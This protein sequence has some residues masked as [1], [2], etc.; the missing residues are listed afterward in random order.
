LDDIRNQQRAILPWLRLAYFYSYKIRVAI[1][2]SNYKNECCQ[3]ITRLE[4]NAQ[5]I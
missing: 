1:G 3:R 5:V 4:E 2:N